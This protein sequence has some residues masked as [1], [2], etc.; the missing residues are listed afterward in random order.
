MNFMFDGR[1]RGWKMEGTA[2]V[3]KKNCNNKWPAARNIG[4]CLLGDTIKS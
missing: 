2:E 1:G 3:R 4:T